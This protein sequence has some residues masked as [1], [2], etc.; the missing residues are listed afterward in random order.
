MDGRDEE[1]T[2]SVD[3]EANVPGAIFT[4]QEELI[5]VEETTPTV[6]NPQPVAPVPVRSNATTASGTG[7]I[8]LQKPKK[9]HKGL[10]A[11][12]VILILAVAAGGF[13]VWWALN[14]EGAAPS[15]LQAFESYK[16]YLVNGPEQG[17]SPEETNQEW[18]L[19]QMDEYY[20]SVD[21]QREYIKELDRRFDEF[22]KLVEGNERLSGRLAAYRGFYV[23]AKV[24]PSLDI[25][26]EDLIK[27][28]DESRSEGAHSF[29]QQATKF[30]P[31]V[32]LTASMSNALKAYLEADLVALEIYDA[33]GCFR[34]GGIDYASCGDVQYGNAAYSEAEA[35]LESADRLLDNTSRAVNASF[36]NLTESFSQTLKEV[37]E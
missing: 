26:V 11:V 1:N 19:F 37:Y 8:K 14:R 21:E 23:L 34:D 15:P 4:P 3:N 28:Y 25:Y 12:V 33:A 10:V 31:E 7:D 24:R 16:E 20:D 5:E 9:S 13:G 17:E 18:F 29:I 32:N 27:S 6:D 2:N 22:A 35:K 36:R 30:E